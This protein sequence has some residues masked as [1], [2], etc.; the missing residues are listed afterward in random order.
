MLNAFDR[1]KHIKPRVKMPLLLSSQLYKSF[2]FT[3]SKDEGCIS[4]GETASCTLSLECSIYVLVP[5]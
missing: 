5:Q 3:D 1:N 2:Y 4:L